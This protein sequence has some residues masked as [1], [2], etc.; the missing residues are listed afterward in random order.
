[1]SAGLTTHVLDIALGRP[2]AG[3]R[4]ELRRAGEPELLASAITNADGRTAEPLLAELGRGTF[5]LTFHTG[6]YLTAH[7]P[8]ATTQFF[9]VI[10]IRFAISD[11]LQHHHVPLLLAPHGYSTYRG[12]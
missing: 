10:P 8:S 9:D 4:V 5:E 12:S 2:A 11:P 6:G 3:I 1:V 7:H